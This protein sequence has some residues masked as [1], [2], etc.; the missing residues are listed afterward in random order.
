MCK[1]VQHN[2]YIEKFIQKYVVEKLYISHK[3]YNIMY[4]YGYEFKH[5]QNPS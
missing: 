5:F 4:V 3:I 2:T 1:F